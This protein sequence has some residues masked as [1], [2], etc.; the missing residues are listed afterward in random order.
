MH[1]GHSLYAFYDKDQKLISNEISMNQSNYTTINKVVVVPNHAKYVIIANQ[2]QKREAKLGVINSFTMPKVKIED[3]E[4]VISRGFTNGTFKETTLDFS[5]KDSFRN[6]ITGNIMEYEGCNTTELIDI[7]NYKRLR[8][9]GGSYLS[10]ALICFYN[11]LKEIISTYPS[12]AGT[13]TYNNEIIDIPEGAYYIAV[14][15]NSSKIKVTPKIEYLYSL[16]PTQLM[17]WE[18]KKWTCVGDSLTE[19]NS[20]TTKHYHTY[21]AENTGITIVNMGASG[22][23]YKRSEENSKAFYQRISNVPTDS[24]VVTIFGSGNDLGSGAAL[25][26]PTDTGTTTLC[27]CINTTID[28]LYNIMPSVQ[29][30]IITPTPWVG[31]PTSDPN[32]PMNLYANAIVEICKLRGIPCLDLYHCSNLRPWDATF[33]TLAYSK[34]DGNG[35][36]PDETGHKIIA[37]RIKAFIETL[38]I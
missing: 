2:Q 19:A 29:L 12:S 34:D 23:G 3:T 7:S 36:H 17:K 22:T 25:G 8:I 1:Y 10:S 4:D 24:D 13:M 16:A 33:R 27:G 28:N 31:Y 37:S 14:N 9:T 11:V 6:V 5:I 18:G 15:D 26:N 32:N 38:L 21:I 30:G 35:V 20:R